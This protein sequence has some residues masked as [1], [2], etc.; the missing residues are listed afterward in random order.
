M[1]NYKEMYTG[2]YAL[3]LDRIEKLVYFTNSTMERLQRLE[4]PHTKV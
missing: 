2:L 3:L 4:K 1:G